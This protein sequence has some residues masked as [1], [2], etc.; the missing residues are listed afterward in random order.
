LTGYRHCSP[1]GTKYKMFTRQDAR[2]LLG[3]ERLTVI[4]LPSALNSVTQRISSAA[5]LKRRGRKPKTVVC[6]DDLLTKETLTLM[7]KNSLRERVQLIN[8]INPALKMTVSRL[9]QLYK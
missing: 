9:R 6:S 2:K 8:S 7:A 4:E 3:R 1:G 5:F